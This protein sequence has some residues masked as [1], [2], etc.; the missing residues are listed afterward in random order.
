[1]CHL[2]N[3][4]VMSYLSM[5]RCFTVLQS[6]DDSGIDLDGPIKLGSHSIRKELLRAVEHF[7][8]VLLCAALETIPGTHSKIGT[9]RDPNNTYV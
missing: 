6:A 7:L 3:Q 5:H 4:V 9:C 8:N 2:Y 1:M